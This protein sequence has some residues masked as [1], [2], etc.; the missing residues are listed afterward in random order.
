MSIRID[1][2]VTRGGDAGQTSLGDGS[3]V[4]KHA[5]RIEAL[6][7]LDDLNA[8][9]GLLRAYSPEDDRVRAELMALQNLLFDMGADICQPEATGRASAKRV[10]EE[11]VLWL[12]E[13]IN[14]MQKVQEPLTSFVLPGGSVAAAWAHKARTQ[15]RATERRFVELAQI[16]PFN[17]VLLKILN[18]LSDYFF[19]LSRYFN[20]NGLSDVL[21]QP[22]VK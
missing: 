13:K 19:V 4:F 18:R 8:V 14:T 1:R 6:G 20:N 21:W 7:A 3:R 11:S 2:V 16:E 17:T 5:P 12:E 15:A 10:A 9:V 22:A